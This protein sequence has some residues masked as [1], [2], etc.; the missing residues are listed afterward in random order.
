MPIGRNVNNHLLLILRR[1]KSGAMIFEYEKRISSTDEG[2][3][4]RQYIV[5][6]IEAIKQEEPR[7]TEYDVFG[8][9][10]AM[11]E[12]LVNAIKH[13]NQMDPKKTVLVRCSITR[14]L[15]IIILI[16]DQGVG[17]KPEEVPDPTD[18]ENLERPCGRGVQLMRAFM[19]EVTYL[20][21]Y[22]GEQVPE[23]SVV[24]MTQDLTHQRTEEL[25]QQD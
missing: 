22:D 2:T 24:E 3:S 8:V 16:A 15:L 10:L 9:M 4:V 21:F 11:E 5:E 17:F 12:A 6:K 7:I 25:I 13:G 20:S 23:G 19:K 1:V 18:D 14:D